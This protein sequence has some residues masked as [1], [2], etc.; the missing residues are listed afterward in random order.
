MQ[1]FMRDELL[2]DSDP[3]DSFCYYA[4]YCMLRDSGAAQVDMETVVSMA[5]KRLQRRAG[6]F[7]DMK[8]KQSFLNASRW[9]KMLMQAAREYKLV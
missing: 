4:W 7:D 8:A 2:P 5:Y 9:N 6:R 1:R 3:S